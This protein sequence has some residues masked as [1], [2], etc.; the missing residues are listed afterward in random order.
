[1][2]AAHI[3]AEETSPSA[4][5]RLGTFVVRHR[6]SVLISY[7]LVAVVA[8]VIGVQVFGALKSEGFADP[9]S[10][11]ARAA[12]YLESEFGVTDPVAV[13]VVAT[14]TGVDTD[15]AAAIRLLEEVEATAGVQSVVSYWSTGAP[16]LRGLDGRTAQ[17]AIFATPDADQEGLASDLVEDFA[18]Q[19]G[20][21]VVS[22]FGG[23][24]IGNAFREQ[25]SGDLARAEM[26]A[27]PLTAILLVFVLGSVVAAGLPLPHRHCHDPRH[28][29]RPL[30]HLVL[31]GRIGLLT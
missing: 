2:N 1:M 24:V 25:I 10:D 29:P 22:A 7:C 11:S 13:L 3:T 5:T 17:V 4:F 8:G 28:L 14:P 16:Q 26:I 6:W 30:R 31:H 27:V 21:L 12:V 20:D 9:S 19:Q 15:A 18:G 23:E